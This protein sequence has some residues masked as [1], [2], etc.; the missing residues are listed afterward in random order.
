MAGFINDDGFSLRGF[1]A[2]GADDV[3]T[4]IDTYISGINAEISK[5]RTVTEEDL[6]QAL[7][8]SHQQ[9][10]IKKY[11]EETIKELNKVASFFEDF[12]RA[13]LTVSANYGQK[14]RQIFTSDVTEAKEQVKYDEETNITGVKPFSE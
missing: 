10:E 5:M 9:S 12:K 1:D 3:C 14:Q 11:I 2:N 8:G 6:D 13:M 7:K 4:A